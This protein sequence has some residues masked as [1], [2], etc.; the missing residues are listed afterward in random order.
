MI[1]VNC[2]FMPARMIGVLCLVVACG[3]EGTSSAFVTIRDDGNVPCRL[4]FEVV[5]TLG[6][7]L[8]DSFDV[9]QALVQD[10]QG[11]FVTSAGRAGFLILWDNQGR[12]LRTIGRSGRGPGE[13]LPGALQ[14]YMDPLDSLFVRDNAGS[15]SVFSP[16][17]AFVR[18]MPLGALSRSGGMTGYTAL[19]DNGA[20][21]SSAPPL[22][23]DTARMFTIADKTGALVREFGDSIVVGDLPAAAPPSRL[24]AYSGGEHFWVDPPLRG[25]AA[26]ELQEWSI[27]GAF[28]RRVV[29][30]ASW[31]QTEAYDPGRE[32]A[33]QLPKSRVIALDAVRDD[34]VLVISMAANESWKPELAPGMSEPEIAAMYDFHAEVLDPV[35]ARVLASQLPG[36]LSQVPIAFIPRMRRGYARG[37]DENGLPFL[38]V[39][40]YGL[41][42]VS[43]S[44]DSG[45]CR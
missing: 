41:E 29:R 12:P 24:L 39:L 26:Y 2:R 18:R 13:F 21:L 19:L 4:V 31:F 34:R 35:E 14:L 43:L 32:A 28:V 23:L 38:R 7:T 42:P 27:E 25:P 36:D 15:W 17:F 22:G 1:P 9:G 5:A 44:A 30:E 45:A 10:S 3:G 40:E 20:I 37:E 11:R 33:F 8:A 16:D 6:T